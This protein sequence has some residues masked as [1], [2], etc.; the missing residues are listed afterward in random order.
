MFQTKNYT[1]YETEN[2]IIIALNINFNLNE[3]K[4]VFNEQELELLVK[5]QPYDKIKLPKNINPEKIKT[6]KLNE[7]T[8]RIEIEKLDSM[9]EIKFDG[10]EK[11]WK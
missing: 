7:N 5:E 6:Q 10:G 1:I 2:S 8:L 9:L 4:L 3:L 11:K